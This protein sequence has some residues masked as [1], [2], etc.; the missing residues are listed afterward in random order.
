MRILWFTWKDLTHPQAGGAEVVNEELAK[1]LVKD[2][3]EVILLVGGYKN[4]IKE[5]VIN[6]YKVI[7]VG[8]RVTVYWEAYKYYKKHLKGWADLIIEEI[9]TIPFM[10]QWYA[11]EKRVLLIYQLCRE[12]W[13]YQFYFPLNLVGYLIEPI[14][15]WL[16]R[17]NK[18]LTESESTKKD[19]LKYGF[20]IENIDIFP[21]GIDIEPIKDISKIKKYDRFTVLSLGSIRAM[22]RT[23]DQVKA[24]E[25]AKK[26]IPELQ[27]KI[28][29]DASDSYG[30]KVLQMIKNSPYKEDIDYLGKVSKEK[31]IELMQKSHVILVTS[32]KE[33]WGL[34]VTEAGS[35]GTPAIVYDVDG[36][37]DSVKNNET[38]LLTIKNTSEDIE[39]KIVQIAS[40]LDL[41]NILQSKTFTWSKEF[42]PD[43][44]YQLFKSEYLNNEQ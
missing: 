5:E 2:G 3:H 22:K 35:Q 37:R 13:F 26:E 42:T 44:S 32:V 31:K 17:D 15:L 30:K 7:R 24:F 20:K 1:R 11:K 12:I 39:K 27:M 16:L 40:N 38:G 33:G 10:T 6:E 14:Y 25:L 19:L 23:A 18:V 28:A 4:A 9:N 8:N 36:L 34:I 29:G 41:Y 21:L 43:K